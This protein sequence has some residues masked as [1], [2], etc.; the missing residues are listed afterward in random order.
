MATILDGLGLDRRRH[1]RCPPVHGQGPLLAGDEEAAAVAHPERRRR[2][3]PEGH[4]A[5]RLLSVLLG[6]L[7]L[8][9]APL[10]TGGAVFDEHW[11]L[12]TSY[13]TTLPGR[14]PLAASSP[15]P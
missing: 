4:D 6:G 5:G 10:A 15:G 11:L 12:W 3:L 7:V 14:A 8:G 1:D 2:G 9:G 13:K